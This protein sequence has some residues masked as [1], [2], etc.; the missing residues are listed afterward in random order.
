MMLR[1]L[2]KERF[3]SI[4]G[5]KMGENAVSHWF[6]D[7]NPDDGKPEY[8][9]ADEAAFAHLLAEALIAIPKGQEEHYILKWDQD[10]A[11]VLTYLHNTIRDANG[12][13]GPRWD[14][15]P[16]EPQKTIKLIDQA[17][18]AR[19]YFV[20]AMHIKDKPKPKPPTQD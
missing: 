10:V 16:T 19:A 9:I 6:A 15:V 17:A 18:A 3:Y 13:Y 14:A 4:A 12:H 8:V 2:T 11:S 7:P 20:A 5:V 1:M